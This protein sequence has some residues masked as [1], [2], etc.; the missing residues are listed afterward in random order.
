MDLTERTLLVQR[1]MLLYLP[2]VA[3]WMPIW[4]NTMFFP[5]VM[6]MV[7]IIIVPIQIVL[8]IVSPASHESACWTIS[9]ANTHL[10][11]RALPVRPVL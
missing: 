4:I 2:W 11:E 5:I 6:L 7:F 9:G 3:H 8:R 1:V 10:A